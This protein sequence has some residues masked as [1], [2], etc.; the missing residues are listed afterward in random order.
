M[1]RRV[2]LYRALNVAPGE[3]RALL[4]AFVY[5]Y[6]ILC[7]Y[8]V[9]RPLRDEMGIQGGV[10]NLQW[11]FLGTFLAMLA[12]VPL[13]GWLTSRMPRRRFLPIVYGIVIVLLLLFY[14]WFASGHAPLAAARAFYV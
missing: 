4:W 5:F 1:L 13:F 2:S 3:L 6:A 10:E 9:I 11:L 12:V 8:Y 7:S 14:A